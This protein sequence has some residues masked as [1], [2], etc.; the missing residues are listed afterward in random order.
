MT[1]LEL[2]IWSRLDTISTIFQIFTF[3]TG[4]TFAA[5]A[6]LYLVFKSEGLYSR[7]G[8]N[9]VRSA[10]KP[11]AISFIV[12]I[13]LT[14][15]TPTKS[16]LALMYGMHWATNNENVKALPDEA[17]TVIREWINEARPNTGDDSDSVTVKGGGDE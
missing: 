17:V 9:V 15:F 8:F 2:Y 6:L 3:L 14:M 13:L 1:W 12:L 10:L 11:T 16:D 7:D 4:V 5:L